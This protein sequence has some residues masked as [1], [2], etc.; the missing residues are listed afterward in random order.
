[1]N[2]ITMFRKRGHQQRGLRT[3]QLCARRIPVG[4]SSGPRRGVTAST[5]GDTKKE[6]AQDRTE[7]RHDA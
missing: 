3:Q 4:L 2:F 5:V 6:E 1:M 7:L